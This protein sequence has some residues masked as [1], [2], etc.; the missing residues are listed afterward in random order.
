MVL[1][2]LTLATPANTLP[3]CSDVGGAETIATTSL[4]D[5]SYISGVIS[6][7]KGNCT[8]KDKEI[9]DCHEQ[10][11]NTSVIC[12]VKLLFVMGN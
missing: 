7:Q 6:H 10:T 4:L 12:Y 5:L 8:L 9:Q 3:V 1:Y 11:C 2:R